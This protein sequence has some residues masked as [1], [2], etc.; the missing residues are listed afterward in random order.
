ML[1]TWRYHRTGTRTLPASDVAAPR[2][3]R[4]AAGEEGGQ[5][6]ARRTGQTPIARLTQTSPTT[7]PTFS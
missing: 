5:R 7:M 3:V 6:P 1:L 4:E 2:P